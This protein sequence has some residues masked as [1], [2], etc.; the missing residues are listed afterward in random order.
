MPTN[1]FF[2]HYYAENEQNLI[3][4]M[5]IESI[6]IQGLN[7]A[8]IPRIQSDMQ[9]LFR[10]DPTNTFENSIKIE[11]YPASV[12]GF[13]G[14][15]M[16][17]NFGLDIKKSATFIVSKTRFKEE[18]PLFERAREG[19][20]LIM[21]IT[22]AILEIKNV[23]L[24]SPFFENGKQYVYELTVETFEYSHEDINTNDQEL[25]DLLDLNM[26]VDDLLDASESR[27]NNE[28]IQLDAD[29][30]ITFDPKNPFGVK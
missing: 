30:I 16:F 14:E 27:G 8:Y 24:E 11:M 1:P 19:D 10:E 4:S 18:F 29:E 23:K 2:N 22:N 13:D 20:L 28:N 15:D 26:I 21:P 12:D 17:S 3:D 5:V 9:H 7:I 25:D 6:Q